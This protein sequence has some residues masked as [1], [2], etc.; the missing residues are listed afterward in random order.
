MD[1]WR[2]LGVV[3]ALLPGAVLAGEAWR[4]PYY[5]PYGQPSVE[6]SIEQQKKLGLTAE[7]IL[8]IAELRRDLEKERVKL[9]DDLKRASDAVAAANAEMGRL[10]Q[11]IRELLTTR[12]QKVY[13]TVLTDAQRKALERNR[14]VEQ[15][16][17][18]LRG[19]Q[20][21]L[22]LT[23]V[24]VEDI[25]GLL[26]PVFEKYAKMETEV[27]DARERLSELRRAEK[28][29]IAAIEKAENEVEVLSKRTFYQERQNELMDKMRAGLLPDQLE[30]LGQVHR[31]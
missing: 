18:W 26:V 20:S 7:Q 2:V 25:S 15:A 14:V 19:Y 1:S 22:K 13:D 9:E 17:Q 3:T 4:Y 28:L 27:S 24:Q 30:K 16:K 8:K 12:L 5:P 23:D 29:E 31:R 21:W 10:N 11:A 6:L